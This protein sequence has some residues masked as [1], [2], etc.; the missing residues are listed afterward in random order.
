MNTKL[1]FDLL[2]KATKSGNIFGA[3]FVKTNKEIRTGAFRGGVKIGVTGKGLNYKPSNVF[4][5][6]VYDMNKNGFRTIKAE[7]L[8][9][10]RFKGITYNFLDNKKGYEI[11]LPF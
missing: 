7:N 5:V 8:K 9:Q 4:N 2:T 10:L 6:I 11:P 3:T 1:K